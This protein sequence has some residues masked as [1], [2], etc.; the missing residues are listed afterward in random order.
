MNKNF[1]YEKYKNVQTKA[2]KRKLD[3]I[4]VQKETILEIKKYCDQNKINVENILC[5]GTRNGIEQKYFNEIFNCNVLGTEISDT[6]TK[7][8]NTIQWDFH[9]FKSEWENKFDIVY[10]NSWDHCYDF[11][12]AL[13]NWMKSLKMDGVL[14]L[15]HTKEHEK[16][17]NDVDCFGLSKEELN[18][19]VTK[20]GFSVKDI[21][22]YRIDKQNMDLMS[23]NINVF[24]LFIISKK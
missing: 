20:C 5:H 11:N 9:D 2:N 21:I 8:E 12:K 14:V 23:K 4:W 22:Q 16:S 17:R 13:N 19:V 10:T 24:S 3:K 15:E 1:D 6:A 18:N 7:F